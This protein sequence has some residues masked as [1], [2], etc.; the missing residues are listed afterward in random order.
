MDNSAKLCRRK[1]CRLCVYIRADISPNFRL[2]RRKVSYS[3]SVSACPRLPN[4]HWSG[5]ELSGRNRVSHGHDKILHV[6]I[7]SLLGV[8]GL[9]YRTPPPLPPPTTRALPRNLRVPFY[10]HGRTFPIRIKYKIPGEAR[11]PSFC[12]KHDQPLWPLGIIYRDDFSELCKSETFRRALLRKV[13]YCF[14]KYC[15]NTRV[16]RCITGVVIQS[17]TK[18]KT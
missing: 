14:A 5:S 2:L 18:H 3:L 9:P 7:E 8:L 17:R 11:R 13:S 4:T 10:L 12:V 6:F 16:I 15:R 1:C